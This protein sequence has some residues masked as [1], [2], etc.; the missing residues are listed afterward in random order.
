MGTTNSNIHYIDIEA[1]RSGSQLTMGKR[2]FLIQPVTD[3]EITNAL[4]NIVDLKAPGID[5]YGAKFFKASWEVI[6]EDVI[7][8]TRDF[9]SHWYDI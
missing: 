3:M 4:M 8:A 2:A 6:K 1:M 7:A 9:F 5:G